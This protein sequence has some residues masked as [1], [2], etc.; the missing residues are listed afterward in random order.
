MH[1][2]PPSELGPD[3]PIPNWWRHWWRRQTPTRQDR[4]AM[5]A[6]LA[7]AITG[8]VPY[9]GCRLRRAAHSLRWLRRHAYGL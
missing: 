8:G 2:S 7:A 6:P 5:L 1:D 3:V 4:F 9:A